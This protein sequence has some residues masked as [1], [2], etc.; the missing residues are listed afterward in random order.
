MRLLALL[1]VL[2]A[3]CSAY[4]QAIP[5]PTLSARAWILMDYASGQVLAAQEPDLKLEPASLTKV[6]T[7]YL[8]A[9][10]C[11][12]SACRCNSRS[13]S[14]SAPGAPRVRAASSR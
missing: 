10:A 11:S 8:V 5:A 7:T 2:F 4:A 6:M 13:A 1:F 3:T 9:E 12:R 14:P